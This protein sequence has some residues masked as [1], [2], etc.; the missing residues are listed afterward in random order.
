MASLYT[1][2][3]L[4]SFLLPFPAASLLKRRNPLLAIL[5]KPDGVTRH[6]R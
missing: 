1:A 5:L 6:L 2:I 4:A 3:I